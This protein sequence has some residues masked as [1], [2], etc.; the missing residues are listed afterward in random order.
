MLLLAAALQVSA[1]FVQ[2]GCLSLAAQ[3]C[4]CIT[5]DADRDSI[6]AMKVKDIKAAL[7][8]G[9]IGHADAVEKSELV[10]R[11]VEAQQAG[12]VPG[13]GASNLGDDDAPT[14]ADGV[15]QGHKL[16]ADPE[17]AAIMEKLQSNPKLMQAAM[18]MAQHGDSA[19]AKYADD[20]EVMSFLRTLQ[21]IAQKDP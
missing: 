6:A 2:Q 5:M 20:E 16:M 1:F 18:E 21:K 9:G 12:R 14:L 7:E 19:V 4:A 8:A 3:C 17:G 15:E 10:D 13:L 11:L